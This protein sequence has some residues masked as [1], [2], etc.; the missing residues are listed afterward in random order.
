MAQ[1]K[2]WPSTVWVR[3]NA[4]GV[5]LSAEHLRTAFFVLNHYKMSTS[6]TSGQ[7]ATVSGCLY[8][9]TET[10]A[11]I[12]AGKEKR[13]KEG[14]LKAA[15]DLSIQYGIEAVKAAI[16]SI[17]NEAYTAVQI[18]EEIEPTAEYWKDAASKIDV[19][20]SIASTLA[21]I[22]EN[23]LYLRDTNEKTKLTDAGVLL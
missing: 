15:G 21:D 18:A 3:G 8:P 9:N 11:R 7:Q 23:C 1:S 13:I 6:N 10:Q 20:C 2:I 22:Q 12:L 17:R 16:D 19:L 4:P 5:V 14:I